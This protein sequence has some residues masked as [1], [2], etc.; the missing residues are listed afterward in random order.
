MHHAAMTMKADFVNLF[1]DLVVQVWRERL[2]VVLSFRE[3]EAVSGVFVTEGLTAAISVKGRLEGHVFYE[4]PEETALAIAAAVEGEERDSVDE[5]LL[6]VIETL[7]EAMSAGTAQALALAGFA[8][9][10]ATP[11]LLARGASVTITEPQ[12]RAH[13]GSDL[14]PLGVRV[15]LA[16]TAG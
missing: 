6:T 1:L 3:A 2:P 12:I 5:S 7:A 11:V 8:S 16:E 14:G 4:F 9:E 15:S 13:F 10:V